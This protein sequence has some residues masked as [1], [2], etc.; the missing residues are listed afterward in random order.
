[1]EDGVKEKAPLKGLA[2][3]LLV[4]ACGLL[5]ILLIT[6]GLYYRMDWDAE[7]TVPVRQKQGV[8]VE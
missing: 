4:A 1:M 8:V 7:G 5:T 6:A 2:K 3:W